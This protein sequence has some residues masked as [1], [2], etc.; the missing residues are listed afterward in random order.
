MDKNGNVIQVLEDE[1]S[2]KKYAEY[3]A[4]S[5][6]KTINVM[7]VVGGVSTATGIVS[8]VAD[9]MSRQPLSI[10]D[11]DIIQKGAKTVGTISIL[12]GIAATFN[13]STIA[14][15]KPTFKNL[16]R[17]GAD[18]FSFIPE[19]GPAISIVTNETTDLINDGIN[20]GLDIYYPILQKE[21]IFDNVCK[22]YGEPSFMNVGGLSN[23][24]VKTILFNEFKTF[25]GD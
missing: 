14:I 7:D 21:Q 8:S 13:D 5:T 4:S 23:V 22:I 1:K 17:L 11:I 6:D 10:N 24:D 3:L 20:A 16:M 25:F 19:Y 12:T 15:E 2:V 18:T 9:K